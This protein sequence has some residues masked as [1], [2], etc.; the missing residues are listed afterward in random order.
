MAKNDEY[1]KLSTRYIKTAIISEMQNKGYRH[2]D[3]PDF[4]VKFNIY[5]KEK[6]HV[7]SAPDSY[8]YCHFRYNYGVWGGYS[9]QET[10]VDQYTEGTL[11][12]DVV[13][14]NSKKL[15]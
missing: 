15:L 4:W 14:R 13:D 5:T 7:T 9:N 2:A 3:N 8:P 11:N 12:I 1:N 10:Q 6:I